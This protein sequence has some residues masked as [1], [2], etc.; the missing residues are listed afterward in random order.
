MRPPRRHISLAGVIVGLSVIAAIA[1]V[2]WVLILVRSED[3]PIIEPTTTPGTPV[4]SPPATPEAT[5]EGTPPP[6]TFSQIPTAEPGSLPDLLNYSPDRIIIESLPLTDVASYANIEG[7]MAARGVR[8]PAGPDDPSFP[9]W[10][11]ELDAL[12]L[13]SILA[14]RGNDPVWLETYGFQ[15]RDVH[16]VLAVGQA[17]DFVLVL[18]GDFDADSLQDAWVQSGYQAVRSQDVTLWSLFPGDAIDLSAPASR[19]ALGSFNNVVLLEDGTLIATS[20]LARLEEAVAVIQGNA[21]AISTNPVLAPFLAPS[22]DAESLVTAVITRGTVLADVTAPPRPFASPPNIWMPL[23]AGTPISSP[24]PP[25]PRVDLFLMGLEIPEGVGAS[26]SMTLILSFDS[27]ED[28]TEGSVRADRSLRT[29]MSPVTG[30]PYIVR[31][32]PLGQRV[33]SSDDGMAAL[34]LRVYLERGSAD[35]RSILEERD[36]GFIMWEWDPDAE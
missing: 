29:G 28:A 18:K 30:E 32:R 19:P 13:P 1:V 9:A 34:V 5:A 26:P 35:W 8:I 24:V 6:P 22:A 20:R 21:P 4:Y 11:R 23:M 15:L 27:V 33:L 7:W 3:S 25:M 10:E 16:Q 14:T 17:P 12:A 36:L 2:V 31:V